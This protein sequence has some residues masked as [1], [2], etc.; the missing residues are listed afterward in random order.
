M[1]QKWKGKIL[2]S[3]IY[4]HSNSSSSIRVFKQKNNIQKE[5]IP[6]FLR[7]RCRPAA[8]GRPCRKWQQFR[9][10]VNER[11]GRQPFDGMIVCQ[12][13]IVL[14]AGWVWQRWPNVS[15]L[16]PASP[17]RSLSASLLVK[18]HGGLEFWVRYASLTGSGRAMNYSSSLN[19]KMKAR[20]WFV[21]LIL[22]A[23]PFASIIC[24]TIVTLP[25]LHNLYRLWLQNQSSSFPGLHYLYWNF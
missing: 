21:T 20:L 16:V 2:C 10:W 6:M 8:C 1:M 22:F 17:R 13:A 23:P 4:C 19:L 15:R 3:Q 7:Q 5:I 24:N 12:P 9:A 11:V 18:F 14:R 25:I